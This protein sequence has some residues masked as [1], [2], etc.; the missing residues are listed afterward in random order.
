M[1]HRRAHYPVAVALADLPS[2]AVVGLGVG[3]LCVA[4]RHRFSWHSRCYYDLSAIAAA[5]VVASTLLMSVHKLVAATAHINLTVLYDQ[6]AVAHGIAFTLL[7]WAAILFR[8]DVSIHVYKGAVLGPSGDVV[9]GGRLAVPAAAGDDVELQ[10][11]TAASSGDDGEPS[12]AGDAAGAENETRG[13]SQIDSKR[14]RARERRRARRRERRRLRRLRS[15]FWVLGPPAVVVACMFVVS[16]S[17]WMDTGVWGKGPAHGWE[18]LSA[19]AAFVYVAAM[20]SCASALGWNRVSLAY[21]AM[22]IAN[23][24]VQATTY[25]TWAYWPLEIAGYVFKG[26]WLVAC[27][28]FWKTSTGTLP[29]YSSLLP[30]V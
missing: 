8:L 25:T 30:T 9:R 19:T 16:L 3:L 18:V 17:L 26:T 27:V 7:A 22:G 23:A 5:L 10:P 28:M 21:C 20:A 2:V 6:Y 24:I 13:A 12:T 29:A 14:Q 11:L 1:S 15:T 4:W